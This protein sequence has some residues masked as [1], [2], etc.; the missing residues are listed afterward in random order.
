MFATKAKKRVQELEQQLA[1]K[2]ADYE[3]RLSA[4]ESQITALKVE[5]NTH[6]AAR[7]LSQQLVQV[8]LQGS[9]MLSAIR[10]GMVSNAETLLE[11]QEKLTEMEGVFE[12]TYRATDVLKQRSAMISTE[13]SHSADSAAV[14]TDTAAKI[15][16]FVAVIQEISEQ[17]NL[18]ALNAAIEAARAGEQGR[19]FAVVADEVRNLAG[20]AHDASGH[21]N[22]LVQQ[23]L[24]QSK[25][26]NSV[27]GQSLES[28][29]EISASA[30]QIDEVTREV[31]RH[32]EG[33][34]SVIKRNAAAAFLEAVKLDHA[35]WK[36]D[37]Y[38]RIEAGQFEQTVST[39]TECRLGKWYY[40]GRGAQSYS[41]FTAFKKIESCHQAVH[42]EGARALQ[43]FAA[44]DQQRGLACLQAMEQAS[45]NVTRALSELEYEVMR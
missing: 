15:S 42:S 21:I 3:T 36:N 22:N 43:A 11:E 25:A 23:V 44:D 34:R 28:T 30:Q 19:G 38:Q 18:L 13:V 16:N 7:Q 5:I 2:V 33:M 12:H 9:D 31:L 8:V 4:K 37:I 24:E 41:H 39:H 17:T 10:E 20:K 35:V 14:L 40:Q 26:I 32:A 45:L 6:K 1:I 27:V 29:D